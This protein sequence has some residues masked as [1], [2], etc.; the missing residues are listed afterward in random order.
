MQRSYNFPEPAG[1]RGVGGMLVRLRPCLAHRSRER[2]PETP[3]QIAGETLDL[4][5]GL[6]PVGL[7]QPRAV[8]FPPHQARPLFL[9]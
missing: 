2:N 4:V 9:G 5:L 7:A 8:P 1:R 6:G 3:L